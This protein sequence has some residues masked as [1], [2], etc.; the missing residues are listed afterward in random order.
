MGADPRR[1]YIDMAPI[2]PTHEPSAIV[3]GYS[4]DASGILHWKSDQFANLPKVGAIIVKP[5]SEGGQGGEALFGLLQS[6]TGNATI[7]YQLLGCPGGDHNGKHS[8]LVTGAAK[9]I[10]L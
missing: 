8:K 4:V 6:P 9:A 10:A 5:V 1:G 2:A 3:D 7:L